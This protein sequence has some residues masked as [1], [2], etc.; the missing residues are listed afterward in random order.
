IFKQMSSQMS[1]LIIVEPALRWSGVLRRK[2]DA[3]PAFGQWLASAAQHPVG[4]KTI[5]LWFDELKQTGAESE[6]PGDKLRRVLRQLRERVFF[7][8][9]VRDIAGLAPL[10]EVVA[11]MSAL[12][13]LAVDEAYR[14][15]ATELAEI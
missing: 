9:M 12:A 6:S 10:H 5:P 2:L 3:N 7:T 4:R 1:E 15:I 11:A 13:D 8:L 14:L